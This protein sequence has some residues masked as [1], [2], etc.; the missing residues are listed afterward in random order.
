QST[1]PVDTYGKIV[2]LS[3]RRPGVFTLPGASAYINGK[4]VKSNPVKVTVTQPGGGPPG[5]IGLVDTE[6]ESELRPGEDIEAKIKKN[7]FLRV[8]A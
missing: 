6:S 3:P 5:R 2:I 8:E 1:Q 4:L 7:L